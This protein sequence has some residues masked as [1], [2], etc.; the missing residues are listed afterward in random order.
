VTAYLRQ[1]AGVESVRG[2]TADGVAALQVRFD[3]ARASLAQVVAAA[4]AGLLADPHNHHPVT[5]ATLSRGADLAAAI[6]HLVRA[7]G[8]AGRGGAAPVG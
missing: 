6:G 2:V 4:R 8:A 5:V 3:P 7:D 1:V